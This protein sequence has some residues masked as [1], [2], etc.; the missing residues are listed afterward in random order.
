VDA[1]GRP[2]GMSWAYDRAEI[3]ADGMIHTLGVG[4]GI[5][6]AIAL[7]IV[8][9]R[10]AQGSEIASV[11]V[12]GIGLLAVLGLSAAYNMWPVTRVKWMLRRFDHSAIYLLIAG[13]YTPFIVQLKSGFI[14]GGLLV[15]IWMSALAGLALKLFLP[16]RFDR[17]AVMLYLILGWS[18]A[19]AYES[20]AA[21]LS[22]GTL[23]LLAI[24]GALYSIGVIFHVWRSLRFQNAIWHAF[25]LIAACCH[26]FA[27][28]GAVVFA[29]L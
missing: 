7:A 17:L 18:G 29:G 26:Y 19:M 25:V 23:W 1:D 6:G 15:G 4:L 13:T 11:L 27:V 9:S 22:A 16:G 2:H 28:L 14:A 8:V 12:Y 21:T 3:I 5:A 20:I 10:S 24:G